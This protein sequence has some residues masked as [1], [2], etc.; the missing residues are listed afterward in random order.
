MTRVRELSP[1]VELHRKQWRELSDSL[2][3]PLTHSELEALR[4]VGQSANHH[5][6]AHQHTLEVLRRM[7]E[8]WS[9]SAPRGIQG[10]FSGSSS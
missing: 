4:G 7:L 2:P 10:S 5:L 8:I 9:M 3:L 1:Y 6:D